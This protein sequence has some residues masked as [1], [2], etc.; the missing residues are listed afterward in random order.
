MCA[1]LVSLLLRRETPPVWLGLVVAVSLL[2]VE[3]GVVLLLMEI[4]PG[5]A[6]GVVYLLGVLAVST[7]WGF[8]LSAATSVASG[9]TFD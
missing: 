3:S 8:A 9:L 6:F 4:A 2:V 5:S 7:V 1:R